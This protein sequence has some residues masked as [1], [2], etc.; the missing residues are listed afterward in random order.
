MPCCECG[1]PADIEYD[2]KR[3]CMDHWHSYA[4]YIDMSVW[5]FVNE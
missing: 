4:G 2:G 3:Y 1:K 5:D